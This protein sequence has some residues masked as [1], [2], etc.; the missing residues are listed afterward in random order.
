MKK[1]LVVRWFEVT[2][3]FKVL[4][5]FDTE[6]EAFAE[7]EKYWMEEGDYGDTSTSVQEASDLLRMMVEA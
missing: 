5:S 6:E 4:S 1:F 7:A 2:D 3:S